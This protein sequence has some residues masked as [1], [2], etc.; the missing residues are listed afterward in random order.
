MHIIIVDLFLL[1][2]YQC[3][4]RLDILTS[5]Y[6]CRKLN[7][8]FQLDVTALP[9]RSVLDRRSGM[10]TRMWSSDNFATNNILGTLHDILDDAEALTGR[11]EIVRNHINGY[12]GAL[13]TNWR[14]SEDLK[15]VFA[16]NIPPMSILVGQT[17]VMRVMAEIVMGPVSNP[18][19]HSD[20]GCPFVSTSC[21]LVIRNLIRL[22]KYPM[23]YYHIHIRYK[24]F[25]IL[26]KNSYSVCPSHKMWSINSV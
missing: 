13:H 21:S 6:W 20:S 12:D 9:W 16:A 7:I 23:C 26:F 14:W 3:C 5:F 18:D 10:M 4:Q 17:G 11:A 24:I 22:W 2:A 1:H 25:K 15:W 19:Y 8:N